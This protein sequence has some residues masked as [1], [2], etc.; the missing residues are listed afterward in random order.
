MHKY[1]YYATKMCSN[2]SPA[3]RIL[4]TLVV[5]NASA[6]HTIITAYCLYGNICTVTILLDPWY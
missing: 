5:C 2:N 6:D 1:T 3:Q 4:H